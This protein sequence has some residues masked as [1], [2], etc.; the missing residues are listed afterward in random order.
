[1]RIISIEGNIGSG[2]STVI[3]NLKQLYKQKYDH[4]IYFLEE[5]VNEWTE[6]QDLNGTNIIEKF[7][8]D[9]YKYSFSFQ[10]MAYISRLALLKKA[11]KY[12]NENNI[13]LIICERS[14]ETDKN[15]FCKMLYDAKKI[16]EVNYQ[17]YLK[18]FDEFIKEY[19]DFYYI[20]I[21]TEPTKAL[22]RVNKRSRTGETIPLEYL[23]KCND[24]HNDWLEKVEKSKS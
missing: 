19:N 3:N 23:I 2:K 1:M 12:C 15:V 8:N 7:Y 16:E 22:E 13:N 4:E 11:I 10:M 14:L 17:I 9:Q 24:Y 18:W 6:V 21:K 20:Y 5:P